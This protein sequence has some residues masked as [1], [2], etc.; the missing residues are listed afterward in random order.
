[1]ADQTL[2][3]NPGDTLTVTVAACPV[4]VVAE[5]TEAAV[6]AAVDTAVEGEFTPPVVP[7]A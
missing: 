7:A 1:M 6:Q 2:T 3:L 5:P 4:A